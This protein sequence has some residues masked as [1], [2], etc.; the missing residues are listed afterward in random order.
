MYTP[1]AAVRFPPPE[2]S[3]REEPYALFPE[4]G[5]SSFSFI[6]LTVKYSA[7]NLRPS[8]SSMVHWTW[9]GVLLV[10]I[11]LTFCGSH[12]SFTARTGMPSCPT[13]S[14]PSAKASLPGKIRISPAW[15]GV[16][17]VLMKSTPIP[18]TG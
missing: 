10:T 9:V 12:T 5:S 6:M 2:A 15:K 3:S 14:T 1:L 18:F 13:G 11:S 4:L 8:G 16:W 7:G 17:L